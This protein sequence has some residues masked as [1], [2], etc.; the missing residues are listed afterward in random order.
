MS[1]F[2]PDLFPA[3]ESIPPAARLPQFIEQR[4]YLINGELRSWNGDLNAVK[5]P[6]FLKK[7]TG[8]E[9]KI[10]GSTPLLTP[11]EAM[12][13]LDAAVA[14]YDLGHG[15]W[16]SMTVTERI[17]HVEKF[18]AKMREQRSTVVTLLMW[19]IGKTQ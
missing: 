7:G 12:H 10:I 5:S 11:V 15:L 13:A 9:Q 2:L 1:E 8:L 19:E 6:V 14:A 3:E 18:L 4:E 16:P 17:E